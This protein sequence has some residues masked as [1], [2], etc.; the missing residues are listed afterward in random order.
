[1]K[2]QRQGGGGMESPIGDGRGLTPVHSARASADVALH[3]VTGVDE[4]PAG[5]PWF[6]SNGQRPA[7]SMPDPAHAPGGGA[8]NGARSS[9]ID[10]QAGHW[11]SLQRLSEADALS[12]ADVLELLLHFGRSGHK[13]TP[14]AAQLLDRFGSLGAVVTADPGRLSEVLDS[15]PLSVMLLKAVRA[16]VKTIVREPLEDR[17]V[18]SSASALMDYL[19]VTM[20][21]EATEATRILFLDRKNALIKDEIQHRGT[22]DHTPLYPREVVRRVVELGASAVILVHNHPSGDPTP[23]QDD[24]EMTRRLSAALSTI[25]VV[26][27]DHVI[28]GRNKEA[29]LRKLKLI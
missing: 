28:V 22:V 23:S 21:H 14:L 12:A 25:N 4:M 10:L 27:H 19:S 9:A 11:R 6:G 16:A 5:A 26:L 2:T 13:A 29:S 17:P 18:I 8:A 24:V 1:W 3:G 20:R 15:D 7:A